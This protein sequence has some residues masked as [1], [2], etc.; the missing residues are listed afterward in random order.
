MLQFSKINTL[1]YYDYLDLGF[2]LT[3]AAGSDIPWGSTMGE[4]RTFVY[5]G[6]NF[7]ANN[8]FKGLKAGNTFV[9]NGPAVFLQADGKLP[10]SEIIQRKGS[11]TVLS[12]KG[13]SNSSIGVI[14]K[15]T[16]YNSDG[17][18]AEKI[19]T[20]KKDSLVIK[21]NHTLT[22]SQWLAAAVFCE[23][24]AVA[25]TTPIYFIVD[26]QPTWNDKK[27]PA[28]I[29]KQEE[30]INK[31]AQEEKA[32]PNPDQGILTR[33]ENAKVFYKNLREHIQQSGI[34]TK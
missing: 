23:N 15:I 1:D 12:V 5:T 16:I 10:G 20:G 2:R 31:T 6:K 3:A 24:S 33:L 29:L 7:S 19:N 28:I 11:S 13:I 4:V 17:L 18:V 14:S 22:H 26:N 32:L 21:M 25:H 30:A 8:W 34:K 27:A 9:S